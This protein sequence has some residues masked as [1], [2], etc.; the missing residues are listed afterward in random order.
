MAL[1]LDL[2]KELEN[3][4][5]AEATR[6]GLALPEYARRLLAAGPAPGEAPKTGA[7]LLAYWRS[8]KV[9]GSR[10]DIADSQKHARGIRRRAE[11]RSRAQ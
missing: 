4:L 10:P 6:L 5:S 1:T 2:P 7:E 11:R 8:E 9:I 3:E